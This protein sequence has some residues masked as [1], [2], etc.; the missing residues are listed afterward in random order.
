MAIKE[1]NDSPCK[2]IGEG[3]FSAVFFS[4]QFFI[5]AAQLREL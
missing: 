4:I 5:E 2:P 1:R 3:F